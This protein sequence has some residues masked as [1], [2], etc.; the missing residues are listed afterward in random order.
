MANK[1]LVKFLADLYQ[2]Y[3]DLPF[4]PECTDK[5]ASEEFKTLLNEA[6]RGNYLKLYNSED[7]DN[8]MSTK[9]VEG[10]QVIFSLRGKEFVLTGGL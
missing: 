3:G 10:D 4:V 9:Y 1:N 5:K 2:K 6:L 7:L 8:V